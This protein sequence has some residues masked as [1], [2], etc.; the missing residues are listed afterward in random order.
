MSFVTLIAITFGMIGFC[1]AVMSFCAIAFPKT[2]CQKTL[3]C[4]EKYNVCIKPKNHSGSH[5]SAN[6]KEYYDA[7]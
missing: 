1:F 2:M 6:G 5:M 3:C 4:D 7:R